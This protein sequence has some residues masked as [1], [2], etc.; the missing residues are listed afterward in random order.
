MKD[1]LKRGSG[2]YTFET[3][4][5]DYPASWVIAS[6][7]YL[8]DRIVPDLAW[9][10]LPAFTRTG[11]EFTLTMNA[12]APA[13]PTGRIGIKSRWKNLREEPI[14]FR[15]DLLVDLR[16]N[17]P[18]NWS[19]FHN[20]NLPVLCKAASEY[21]FSIFDVGVLL[22]A[23]TPGYIRRSANMFG[24][25]FYC[26]DKEVPIS[27]ITFEPKYADLASD[28]GTDWLA[29][30]KDELNLKRGSA[31]AES[32]KR[33]FLS[34]RKTRNI[35]NE[36][37]VIE[38]LT[39]NGFETIYPEELS[40]AEQ[41]AIFDRAEV[42]V[43]IHG[44]GMAPIMYRGTDSNLRLVVEICPVGHMVKNF[45]MR[46]IASGVDWIGVQGRI[47]KEY[48]PELYRFD[49]YFLKYSLDSFELDL[50]SIRAAL[51]EKGFSTQN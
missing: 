41:F 35:E 39:A 6:K 33:Y 8:V 3:P 38:F 26:T 46:T 23:N 27:T 34:R 22:P 9:I 28:N 5:R 14:I 40:V 1:I 7:S 11:G 15:H 32:P 19:L 49:R 2:S 51:H 24:L 17:A 25:N 16:V 18:Q 48:I 43:A 45:R 44:A 21:G 13:R 37:E 31:P 12:M 36:G 30:Y 4:N 10:Q 50:D 42:I 20:A 29:P 47:K